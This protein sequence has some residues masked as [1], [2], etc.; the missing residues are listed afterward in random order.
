MGGGAVV[1]GCAFRSGATGDQHLC[2]RIAMERSGA[3]E[4]EADSVPSAAGSG[5]PCDLRRE[6]M[7]YRK[8]LAYNAGV[9]IPGIDAES[10]GH[11]KIRGI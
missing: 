11:D 1:G 2:G 8:A 4:R 6:N 3:H 7:G 5:N 9:C 10:G